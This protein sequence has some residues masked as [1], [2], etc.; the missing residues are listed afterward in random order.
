MFRI[1][2]RVFS[3]SRARM[4]QLHQSRRGQVA[5]VL[6]LAAALG[7]I[8]Y[9]ITLNF[10][11]V[12]QVK[13][14]TT[15]GANTAASQM[16]SLMASYGEQL[17]QTTLGGHR[18][19]CS[20]N[21]LFITIIAFILVV[22]LVIIA[23]ILI[24]FFPPAGIGL[25]L[26]IT[27][28]VVAIS[29]ATAA[30]ILQ[31]TVVQPGITSMWNKMMTVSLSI[32][33]QF[34]ERG[35]QTG[36]SAVVSDPVNIPDLIDVDADGYFG[37]PLGVDPNDPN[38]RANDYISRF[39]FY[40]NERIRRV[41][42]VAGARDAIE[43]FKTALDNFLYARG[44]VDWG[45]TDFV[46]CSAVG[47]G[48]HVCCP[49][50][51]VNAANYPAMCDPCCQSRYLVDSLGN[52]VND[53]NGNPMPNNARPACCDLPVGDV[54]KCG[55]PD[56]CVTRS[57]AFTNNG[58]ATDDYPMVYERFYEN[59]DL[60]SAK[61]FRELLGRD[62]EHH[63]YRVNPAEPNW[64]RD[65]VNDRQLL[66]NSGGYPPPEDLPG[67]YL[68][69]TTGFYNPGLHVPGVYPVLDEQDGIFP[70]F[71]KIRDWGTPLTALTYGG[72]EYHW[73]DAGAPGVGAPP[74]LPQEMSSTRL[75]LPVVPPAG[76][77]GST[78]N[79]SGGWCVDNANPAVPGQMPL[80]ADAVPM[81]NEIY[82]ELL[83]SATPLPNRC[84]TGDNAVGGWKR[85]AD[86]FCAPQYVDPADSVQKPRPPYTMACNKHRGNCTEPVPVEPGEP[87]EPP[88]PVACECGDAGSGAAPSEWQDDHLDDLVYGLPE[89]IEWARNIVTTPTQM[90]MDNFEDW[91]EEAADWIEPFCDITDPS[92]ADIN[93]PTCCPGSFTKKNR[94]GALHIWRSEVRDF[95]DPIADWV[96]D[97]DLIDTFIQSGNPQ[98]Q[99]VG[100]SC[101]VNALNLNDAV[102]CVP[103]AQVAPNEFNIN[104]CGCVNPSEAATFDVN[105]NGVRGDLED[106]VACLR[107]NAFDGSYQAVDAGG[108]PFTPLGNAAKFQACADNCNV[109]NCQNLP[110][111]L[112]PNFC[113]FYPFNAGNAADQTAFDNCINS[114]DPPPV[115]PPPAVNPNVAECNRDC[116]NLPQNDP[117]GNSYNLPPFAAPNLAQISLLIDVTNPGSI[118][119]Q[120]QIN[121]GLTF[122]NACADAPTDID[123]QNGSNFAFWDDVE[124][125]IC[126]ALGS[127]CDFYPRF[128]GAQRLNPNPFYDAVENALHGG[129]CDADW[130]L[131][132]P[133]YYKIYAAL[134]SCYGASPNNIFY[135][136]VLNAQGAIANPCG[137]GETDLVDCDDT[138]IA[139]FTNCINDIVDGG[140][141]TAG[142]CDNLPAR[143]SALVPYNIPPYEVGV[144][145]PFV[146][147]ACAEN[148]VFFPNF[149]G[150]FEECLSNCSQQNC[151]AAFW[152]GDLPL[153]S[154]NGSLLNIESRPPVALALPGRDDQ[155]EGPL[156]TGDIQLMQECLAA[157]EQNAASCTA[158]GAPTSPYGVN[159]LGE[160]YGIPM[161]T[162]P[163]G[164]ADTLR[165]C[166]NLDYTTC[167]AGV[168]DGLDPDWGGPAPPLNCLSPT[169][170]MSEI[171]RCSFTWE[172][173]CSGWGSDSDPSDVPSF[174]DAVANAGAGA[175]GTCADP[176]FLPAVLQSAQ[177]AQNQVAKFRTRLDYLETRMKEARAVANDAQVTPADAAGNNLPN[178][179]LREGI[180]QFADF[181]DD[182]TDWDNPQNLPSNFCTTQDSPSE[183]LIQAR[184]D[185]R[186]VP[187]G[188]PS[189]A[190][191]VWQDEQVA[192][193][194]GTLT[195]P[196]WHAVKVEA[197]I[198]K[199]CNNSCRAD[200]S[201]PD[202]RWPRVRTYTK[203]WG[204]TRCYELA[205]TRGMV[206][207]RVIRYD[208]DKNPSGFLFPNGLPIWSPRFYHPDRGPADLAGIIGI[209]GNEAACDTQVDQ[210]IRY[211]PWGNAFMLNENPDFLRND[212]S[213]TPAEIA[214]RLEYANCWVKT[215]DLLRSGIST[216]TCAQ[217]FF[218]YNSAGWGN[219]GFRLKFVPCDARFSRG[220]T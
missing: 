70:F 153:G 10:S 160:S 16:A 37:Y 6:I 155:P 36:L 170:A 3:Q 194:D 205:D 47:P 64:H 147:G 39:G 38:A 67:F 200:G 210:R 220:D 154:C 164:R 134:G 201:S 53:Q 7:L 117:Q 44:G 15:I 129:I 122:V 34:V 20:L 86:R 31:I 133:A 13:T 187:P 28:I 126:V 121:T 207:A 54:A 158:L 206:K 218:N 83:T 42:N 217:Y 72:Y 141:C 102:W 59:T 130:G 93:S 65:F 172:N 163:N 91:Y 108:N 112:V 57:F 95:S 124:D 14:I 161:F 105:N 212:P 66:G 136:A 61:S 127:C 97:G 143:N 151:W 165:G 100:Q 2:N 45:I 149:Y 80:L 74:T 177:E 199:R 27:A 142:V 81:I 12:S 33:D 46:D 25:F 190:V 78:L 4:R 106:V 111:S 23:I 9:A 18:K 50:D 104:E 183:C 171:M 150:E 69:D 211:K 180:N 63:L 119:N 159:A 49:L 76:V 24:I 17:F 85:G 109:Q 140:R 92:C 89:F 195:V 79:F 41:A 166:H 182:E 144:V 202:P 203:H 118:Y 88:I 51:P 135:Q 77:A 219:R 192:K 116:S 107:W 191:Y 71:Y 189:F 87:A 32:T 125:G 30:L 186:D 198:P 204:I 60:G 148:T 120:C 55:N 26:A 56:T 73:C 213:L 167:K 82:T 52:L 75:T 197:R 169:Y 19:I 184:K 152:G 131:S 216:E 156:N 146:G 115:V 48:N 173:S 208:Q 5:L 99:Y 132:D 90:L 8:L 188:L 101:S 179:V 43:K 139:Q 181:L 1:F 215:H 176:L 214:R 145:E 11:R 193:P 98:T 22:I 94:W 175:S 62:D 128:V 40:N 174:F 185:L 29:A 103:P 21:G 35:I 178:G 110:R 138:H 196:Y 68:Q 168:C 113:T 162:A 209:P 58:D 114:G 157:C 84:A 123:C 137:P 96:V